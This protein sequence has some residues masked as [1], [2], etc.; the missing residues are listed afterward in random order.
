M[1]DNELAALTKIKNAIKN[2]TE[3][4]KV[5]VLR[6]ITESVKEEEAENE[7][8]EDGIVEEDPIAEAAH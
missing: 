6:L 3:N 5:R 2:L 1:L 8:V 4:E 7:A